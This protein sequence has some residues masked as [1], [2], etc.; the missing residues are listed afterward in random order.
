MTAE[1]EKT[2]LE[3]KDDGPD[4]TQDQLGVAINYV[5]GADVHQFYLKHKIIMTDR[6]IYHIII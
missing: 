1:Q 3:V 6:L 2:D 4:E 5:L